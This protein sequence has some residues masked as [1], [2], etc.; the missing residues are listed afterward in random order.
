MCSEKKL[1]WISCLKAQRGTSVRVNFSV[2]LHVRSLQLRKSL[3]SKDS[4][5]K[6]TTC[7][8]IWD[9][10][11][12]YKASKK[13]KQKGCFQESYRLTVCKFNKSNTS[14]QMFLT[15]FNDTN[16][17][18][19]RNTKKK[20]N[21]VHLQQFFRQTCLNLETSSL[22]FDQKQLTEQRF[23]IQ[24]KP[25]SW[26]ENLKHFNDGVLTLR[27]AIIALTQLNLENV[28]HF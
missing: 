10:Q 27:D 3:L 20:L 28:K 1:S 25:L 2:K 11:P 4:N 7:F 6:I 9:H 26:K 22:V 5:H 24:L 14:P 21:T 16:A 17:T 15:I 18:K 12:L 13:S 19:L 23:V 8:T